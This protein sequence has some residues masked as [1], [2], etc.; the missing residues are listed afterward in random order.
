MNILTERSEYVTRDAILKLLSDD[1]IARVSTAEAGPLLLE[2]D[3]YVDLGHLNQGV[4]RMHLETRIAMGK[5]IP[6]SAVE[7]ATWAKICTHL[8]T[9][10]RAR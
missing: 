1:E 10:S 4:R 2:G 9:G 6:R 7:D 3:E 5:V 8:G